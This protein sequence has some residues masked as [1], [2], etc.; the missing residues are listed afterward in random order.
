[1]K[2]GAT[3]LFNFNTTGSIVTIGASDTTGAVLV[4]DVKTDSGDPTGG[5]ATN[6][7]MYYNSNSNKFRCYQNGGWT[8]CIGAG[9]SPTLQ[10][11]YNNDAS[12][13]ADITT[14]SG[15][16]TFL[17]KA[18]STFDA[19]ELFDIQNAA[20]T[21]LFTVD[22]SNSRVYIGDSTADATGTVLVLDTKNTSGDPTGVN[23]ATYYNSNSN[24]FRCYQNG[25]WTDCIGAGGGGGQTR[26]ITLVPEYPGGVISA[27]G[28][29][30]NGTLTSDYDGTNVHN[31]YSWS[32]STGSLNDY[33]IIVRTAIPSEY[34][35][36]FGT[37][38]IWAYGN[39]TNTANNNIQVTVRDAAGTACAS[40]VSVL[41]GTATTW[42]EQTVTLSGC[43]FA[44]NDLIVVSVKMSSLS[45]NAVRIGEISYQYTN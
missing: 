1:M 6:G 2:N 19:T 40:S 7:A 24:K 9:S 35:S 25:A 4:L 30:N 29:N 12:G 39:S 11:V 20:G 33:D 17:F 23:G 43:T 22:S 13:V 16:K 38:K 21:Q 44:A 45:N 41:P 37:F 18:G 15:T 36:G 26:K 28:S 14:T 31:Y 5:S 34:A 10:D 27:D 3:N 8:D 32:N 42:V